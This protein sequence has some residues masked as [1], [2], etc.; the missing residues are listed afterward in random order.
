MM[1]SIPTNSIKNVERWTRSKLIS[2]VRNEEDPP[3]VVGGGARGGGGGGGL[4]G[5]P[6][7]LEGRTVHLKIDRGRMWRTSWGDRDEGVIYNFRKIFGL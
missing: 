5:I 4:I 7:D 1:R 2:P 3:V 6:G